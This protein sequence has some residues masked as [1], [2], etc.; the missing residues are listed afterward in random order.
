LDP[1]FLLFQREIN[2]KII[3][4]RSVRKS[5]REIDTKGE[6]GNERE[7]GEGE[8]PNLCLLLLIFISLIFVF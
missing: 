5:K 4:K 8:D 1:L 6:R 2:K 3:K 7:I